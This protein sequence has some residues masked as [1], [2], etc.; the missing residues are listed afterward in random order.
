MQKYHFDNIPTPETA[1]QHV[2]DGLT[3]YAVHTPHPMY[4]GLFNPRPSFASVLADTITAVF[5]PQ[6]A[7]WSHAPFANEVEA[8]LLRAF[9]RR[10]G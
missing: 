6:M 10:F 3:R 7:A 4:Y 5:N 1:L 9:G 8:F 2:L